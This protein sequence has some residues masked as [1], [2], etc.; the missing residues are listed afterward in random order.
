MFEKETEVNDMNTTHLAFDVGLIALAQAVN[1]WW[2]SR[3]IYAN[4]P[5]GSRTF[6]VMVFVMLLYVTAA[7][8]WHTVLSQGVGLES[9]LLVAVVSA[10]MAFVLSLITAWLGM[11]ESKLRRWLQRP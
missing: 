2:F 7:M 11:I 4:S 5:P 3:V 6:D 1:L 8:L 10:V 9:K